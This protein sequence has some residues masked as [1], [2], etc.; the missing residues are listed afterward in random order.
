[1]IE[2]FQDLSDKDKENKGKRSFLFAKLNAIDFISHRKKMTTLTK[3]LLHL[4]V[5]NQEK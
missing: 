4:E 1:M 2:A 3:I 5:Q